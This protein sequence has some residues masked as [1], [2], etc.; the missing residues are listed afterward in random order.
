MQHDLERLRVLMAEKQIEGR[1]IRSRAVLDAMCAVPRQAFA[2]PSIH[3][4]A[5][6]DAAS[7]I[8]DERTR[9]QPKLD[10]L[11]VEALFLGKDAKALE[12]GTGSGTNF[13]LPMRFQAV[14]PPQFD[15][16]VW[17]D[18]T[19]AVVPLEAESTEGLPD[20]HSF[21]L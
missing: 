4:F 10:A 20:S 14:L 19:L 12:A 9:P 13:V 3:E 2:P 15:E 17:L 6:E 1:G 18:E 16:H 5:D 21:G 11:M 7:R 8:D